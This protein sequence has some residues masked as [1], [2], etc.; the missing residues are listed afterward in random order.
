M[1][2]YPLFTEKTNCQDCYKCIRHCPVKAIKVEENSAS[3][4][5]ENCIYCG[6][7]VEICPVGAKKVVNDSNWVQHLIE[8]GEKVVVSLAPSWAADYEY[9]SKE[10][11]ARLLAMGFWKVSE[12]AIGAEIISEKTKKYLNTSGEGLYISSCCP[13]VVELIKKYYP[14]REKNLVPIASPFIAHAKF[15]KKYYG[16]DVH[17]VFLGPCIAKKREAIDYPDLIAGAL[18]FNEIDSWLR[19]TKPMITERNISFSPH[20]AAKGAVYP[21]DGGMIA[22]IKE[23]SDTGYMSF[24]GL[25]KIKE[26][27]ESIKEEEIEGSVFLELMAC[28]GGCINGPMSDKSISLVNKRQRILRKSREKGKVEI[29]ASLYSV[30]VPDILSSSTAIKSK[31]YPESLIVETMAAVGKVSESDELNCGGCGYES[32]KDFTL[33]VLEGKAERSMCVS[34]MRKVAHNKATVLLQRMPYGVVIFDENLR[35]I[36]CNKNFATL[37]GE[38]AEQIFE[39]KPGMEHADLSKLVSFS[40]LL[41]NF[42]SGGEEVLEKD[43]REDKKLYRISCFSI[44]RHKISCAILHNLKSAETNKEEVIRRARK[45]IKE[46]LQTVQNVAFLLGENASSTEALLNSIV[47]SVGNNTLEDE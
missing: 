46:N 11:V 18:T 17:V 8:K 23:Q 45:V 6:H 43:I 20:H 36:E 47:E 2:N 24:T 5:P 26:I 31:E 4:I 12:T 38:E 27:L 32:C 7:C 9:S 13:A 41:K 22:G 29:P 10:M 44:Q 25:L 16:D 21:I 35:I 19:N 28:K 30:E 14:E 39:A 33:A 15:L 34:Y 37:V 3:I 40:K 1:L 42:M